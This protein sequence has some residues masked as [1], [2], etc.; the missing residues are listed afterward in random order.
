MSGNDETYLESFMETLTN[1]PLDLRRTMDLLKDLDMT[2]SG[3]LRELRRLQTQYIQETEQKILQLPVTDLP[4]ESDDEIHPFYRKRPANDDE[5]RQGISINGEAVIPT[6]NEFMEYTMN[7]LEL[8]PQIKKLQ[9]SVLQ[10]ADEKVSVAQQAYDMI[11]SKV[12]RLDADLDSMERL[13][14]ATGAFQEAVTAQPDDLAACQVTP[15]SEWILAKVRCR[16]CA[17]EP[18]LTTFCFAV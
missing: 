4:D 7:S 15:G 6:T 9:K 3:E 5:K 12:Q 16:T 10:K 8:Y 2:C 14:Q 18:F 17:L 1:L 11:D 13:L